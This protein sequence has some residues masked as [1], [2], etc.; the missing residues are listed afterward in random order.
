MHAKGRL[1]ED[2]RAPTI[3]I[4]PQPGARKLPLSSESW[5][6]TPTDHDPRKAWPLLVMLH[7]A[8]GSPAHALSLVEKQASREGFLVLAP[9]SHAGSW[10]V[11]HGGFGP[12]V[13][14]LDQAIRWLSDR[15][16]IEA[17]S[18]AIGGFSD[19]AS[20]ALS[21]G[22]GNGDRFSDVLAF[23]PGFAAPG[24]RVGRPRIYISHGRSDQVLPY[25][26]CGALLAERLESGGYDVLFEPFSGGHTVPQ[27]KVDS[28]VGR[29]LA[30]WRQKT[31]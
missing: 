29:W 14:A 17:S 18:V 24:S 3:E 16:A 10:D 15:Y 21:L 30:A 11:I 20:Y 4:Q 23:S 9:K 19:G 22:L 27:D 8:G 5:L 31:A 7:G 28:A 25:S 12:D 13:R 26:R 2:L 1:N 6:L